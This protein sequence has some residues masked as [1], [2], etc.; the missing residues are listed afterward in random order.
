MDCIDNA[1]QFHLNWDNDRRLA[2]IIGVDQ[3]Q[4]MPPEAQIVKFYMSLAANFFGY[5]DWGEREEYGTDL[6]AEICGDT[7]PR[8]EQSW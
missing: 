8:S 7:K 5:D 2:L 6:G 3:F 1:G 4:V